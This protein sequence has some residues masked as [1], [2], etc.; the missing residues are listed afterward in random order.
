MSKKPMTGSNTL[1]RAR[2]VPAGNGANL[3]TCISLLR[4]AKLHDG[5]R[6]DYDQPFNSGQRFPNLK[7]MEIRSISSN[8]YLKQCEEK[9]IIMQ[10]AILR[11]MRE[12]GM[13]SRQVVMNHQR[14]LKKQNGLCGVCKG[15]I[16][17][18]D[19]LEVHHVEHLAKGGRNLPKNSLLVHKACHRVELHSPKI[20]K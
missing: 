13:Y 7:Q 2:Y 8:Q 9:V 16:I 12:Y 19:I 14:L 18:S 20:D 5:R 17:E 6:R 3:D 11:A 1:Y 15:I 10:D 4:K